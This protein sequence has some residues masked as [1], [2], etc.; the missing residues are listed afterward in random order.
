MR[1]VQIAEYGSVSGG[2]I[3][4]PAGS[5]LLAVGQTAPGGDL[6][7]TMSGRMTYTYDD[8]STVTYNASG[9]VLS[10]TEI[11]AIGLNVDWSNCLQ[12][13]GT[14]MATIGGAATGNALVTIGGALATVGSA[15]A[16]YNGSSWTY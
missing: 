10:Y 13:A 15:G 7:D 8:G 11:P 12:T 16:C 4:A 6:A 14:A 5:P 9:Q 1:V 3:G 2:M